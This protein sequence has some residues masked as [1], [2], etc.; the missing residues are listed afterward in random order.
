MIQLK[1]SLRYEYRVADFE[2]YLSIC[3]NANEAAVIKIKIGEKYWTQEGCYWN[4]E[5]LKKCMTL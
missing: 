2:E 3:L 1:S 4:T 5:N